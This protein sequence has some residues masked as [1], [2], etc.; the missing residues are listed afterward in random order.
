MYRWLC[1]AFVHLVLQCGYQQGQVGRLFQVYSFIEHSPDCLDAAS[2]AVW[3][4]CDGLYI[5]V[6]N[7][8]LDVYLVWLVL[9]FRRLQAIRLYEGYLSFLFDRLV[10][11]VG[12]L[13]G[14]NDHRKLSVIDLGK[15]S[16]SSRFILFR[17]ENSQ[18]QD[19]G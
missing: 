6:V 17:H 9:P 2:L 18:G 5:R 10:G 19:I 4:P 8:C 12:Y 13:S 11:Y 3:H 15:D 1:D 7:H 14:D 16:Y